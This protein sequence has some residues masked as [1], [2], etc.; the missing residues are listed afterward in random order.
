MRAPTILLLGLLLLSTA[1]PAQQSGGTLVQPLE[2]PPSFCLRGRALPGCQWF[3]FAECSVSTRLA[4]QNRFA[5]TPRYYFSGE[6]GALWEKVDSL[7]TIFWI[8]AGCAF[9]AALMIAL[10]VPW[11]KRVMVEHEAQVQARNTALELEDDK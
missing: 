8:N 3:T 5:D 10:M 1:L 4:D 2:R 7:S 9:A 6:I 11:I